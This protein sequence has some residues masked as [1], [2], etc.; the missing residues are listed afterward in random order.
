MKKFNPVI[1]IILAFLSALLA[2][3]VF[4]AILFITIMILSALESMLNSEILFGLSCLIVFLIAGSFALSAL[5]ACTHLTVSICNNKWICLFMGVIISLF[6]IFH[7]FLSALNYVVVYD[8]VRVI[9]YDIPMIIYGIFISVYGFINGEPG[10]KDQ[11]IA[12]LSE[13]T[14]ELLTAYEKSQE[15]I[16]ELTSKIDYLNEEINRLYEENADFSVENNTL[17]DDLKEM[18]I[19]YNAAY[20]VA[21]QYCQELQDLK[22]EI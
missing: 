19:N 1:S 2:L 20:K 6:F 4:E 16:K 8:I 18:E 22:N 10:K 9:I 17:R 3:V 7:I 14:C 13:T 15:K 5:F 21:L 12:E 11:K